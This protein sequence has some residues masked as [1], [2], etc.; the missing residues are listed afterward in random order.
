MAI[1]LSVKLITVGAA[2]ISLDYRH[3]FT[4]RPQPPKAEY[5]FI[6]IGAGTAGATVAARL[7]EQSNVQVLLLEAGGPGN[8][9]FDAPV[10]AN[11]VFNGQWNWNYTNVK[12]SVGIGLKNKVIPEFRGYALGGSS[13]INSMVFNRGNTRGYDDWANN[14]GATGWSWDEVRPYFLKYENNTDCDLVEAYPEWHSTGGPV[15][16]TTWAN[17]DPIYQLMIQANNELGYPT[18]DINGP[19]QLGIALVQ[20]F[21]STRGVRSSSSN[22]YLEGNRRPNLDISVHSR[23]TRVLFSGRTAVGVEYVKNGVTYVAKTRK[24]IIISAGAINSPQILMLSG[25]GPAQH[26]NDFSIP[27]LADL[28]VGIN[29][30]NHPRLDLRAYIKD[31]SLVTTSRLQDAEA[32]TVPALYEWFTN[33]SGPLI[34]YHDTITYFN[35]RNNRDKN[36]PDLA[37]EV[38]LYHQHKD[39]Q[40]AAQDFDDVYAWTQWLQQYANRYFLQILPYHELPRSR[41]YIYLQS[42]NPFAPPILDQRFLTHPK[43]M[44]DFVEIVQ[45]GLYVAERSSLAQYLLPVKPIPGCYACPH[46]PYLYQCDSYIRCHIQQ[47]TLSGLHDCGSVRMGDPNRDDTVLDPRLRVK[48]FK[49]LRVCDASVFP[50]IPNGNTNAATFMTGEK[51]AEM[52]K[53]DNYFNV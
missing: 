1:S 25:I 22:S 36:W 11:L 19:N 12:Q 31:D 34:Q 30:H 49:R 53:E 23:V 7:S 38:R 3:R 14:Y 24:E 9:M 26:L 6:V 4:A 13:S 45:Y 8:F 50:V 41:G 28:P 44:D 47:L 37:L 21:A 42:N 15:Q 16:I 27:V 39:V 10:L 46:T 33:G 51:C 17:P 29:L 32:L 43:D 48:G 18:T 2:L 20:E 40:L 52:V 35:S 5:D